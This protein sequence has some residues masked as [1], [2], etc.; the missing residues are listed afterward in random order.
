MHTLEA[1]AAVVGWLAVTACVA[2][3]NALVR[4]RRRAWE[5]GAWNWMMIMAC[6]L[7]ALFLG[8]ALGLVPLPVV[9]VMAVQ[10]VLWVAG[11]IVIVRMAARVQ[12][13][14]RAD[15]VL[16]E[17]IG[18]L[19]PT[20]TAA[21]RRAGVGGEQLEAARQALRSSRGRT[22]LHHVSQVADEVGSTEGGTEG[23]AAVAES[24]A[25]WRSMYGVAEV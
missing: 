19:M 14:V 6:G 11:L 22:A 24:L 21:Q 16:T 4:G 23:W 2:F 25:R 7:A 15:Q 17:I 3:A 18:P 13:R 5:P 20:V 12:C 1:L 8:Q 9:A 10:V